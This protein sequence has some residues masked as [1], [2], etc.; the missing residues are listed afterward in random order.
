M[1]QQQARAARRARVDEDLTGAERL[2]LAILDH[3]IVHFRYH[4]HDRT[5]E[6]HLLA[7]SL[8]LLHGARWSRWPCC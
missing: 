8:C 6:P 1:R 4:G 2:V 3:R 7:A 5:V